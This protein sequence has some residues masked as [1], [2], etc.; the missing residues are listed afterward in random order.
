MTTTPNQNPYKVTTGKCRLCYTKN[1]LTPDED[2]SYSLMILIPKTDTVTINAL[3]NSIEKFKKDPK[4]EAKWGS[5]FLA[6]MRTPLRDGDTE[7]DLEKGPEFKDHYFVNANT[8][9]KPGVVDARMQEIINPSDIYSG[10]YG[11]VSVVPA[12]YN[13]DGNRGIK[14]YLNNVQKIAEGERLGGGGSNVNDDFTAIEED[15]LS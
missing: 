15:F 10:C 8:Y 6:N 13:T 9:T 14:L 12:A 2:G 7:R 1:V 11:R 3:K 5:K 4:A